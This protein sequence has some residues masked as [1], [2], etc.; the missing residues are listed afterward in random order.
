M[1]KF[2]VSIIICTHNPDLQIFQRLLKVVAAFDHPH[3]NHEVIIVDNNSSVNLCSLPLIKKLSSSNNKIKCICEQSPGLT[4]ARIAGG[5][6]ARFN[7]LLFF[8][9]DNEPAPNYLNALAGLIAKY[10]QV[11]SWGPGNIK[12]EYVGKAVHPWFLEN[13]YIFQEK[14]VLALQ[15]DCKQ[16]WLDCYPI[17]TGLA[18]RKDI[19]SVYDDNISS[20]KFTLSDRIGRSLVSG[21]DTQMV[22]LCIKL[23]FS[24]GISPDL[25]L[26]HLIVSKKTRF[27]YVLRQTYMTASCFV[28]A[29]NEICFENK[30]IPIERT[31]NWEIVKKVYSIF[32]IYL[33]QQP[34]K[35]VFVLLYSRLGEVNARYYAANIKAKP[36][37]LRFFEKAIKI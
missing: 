6:N 9:D 22:L 12:V 11:G 31:T 4:S 14:L 29:Y 25:V 20:G 19:F 30:I 18:V 33:P 24:A 7:W 5:R 32:K 16:E 13:R 27:Q 1:V 17:G 15:Y 37:L 8:D 10:P 3:I 23:G 21:G 34:A 36:V 28:K 2:S 26:N 35:N